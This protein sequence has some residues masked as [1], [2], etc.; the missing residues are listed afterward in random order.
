MGLTTALFIFNLFAEV[1]QWI[2]A[3]FFR[4][5]L[6]HYLD[7]FVVIFRPETSPERLVAK[8]NA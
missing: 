7:N 2:I 5:V 4:W 1:L 3:F 6:C 8:V